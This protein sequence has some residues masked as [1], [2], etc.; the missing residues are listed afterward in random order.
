MEAESSAA[1]NVDKAPTLHTSSPAQP[2]QLRDKPPQ[3]LQKPEGLDAYRACRNALH[4]LWHSAALPPFEAPAAPSKQQ[5][6][7]AQGKAVGAQAGTTLPADGSVQPKAAQHDYVQTRQ[8]RQVMRHQHE[9]SNVS[10]VARSA[11]ARTSAVSGQSQKADR[12]APQTAC[13]DVSRSS[14]QQ[15][16]ASLLHK[17]IKALEQASRPNLEQRQAQKKQHQQGLM[18]DLAVKAAAAQTLQPGCESIAQQQHSRHA[19]HLQPEQGSRQQ[20]WQQQGVKRKSPDQEAANIRQPASQQAD[21]EP[22][23]RQRLQLQ[24]PERISLGPQD[25]QARSIQAPVHARVS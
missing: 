1:A 15:L 22:V 13:A 23:K 16:P 17:Q 14:R 10:N 21:G 3:L 11:A 18:H 9:Q 24:D 20:L 7:A 8:L 5:E 25:A 2:K 6:S 12:T 19:M 4:G